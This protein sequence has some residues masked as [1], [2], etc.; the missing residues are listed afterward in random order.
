MHAA[1]TIVFHVSEDWYCRSSMLVFNSLRSGGA[2]VIGIA[3]ILAQFTRKNSGPRIFFVISMI[4]ECAL[5]INLNMIKIR[6]LYFPGE[7]IY[8]DK[9][10]VG[11]SFWLNK[12]WIKVLYSQAV[13]NSSI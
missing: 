5:R 4:C 3:K 1:P 6:V 11:S 10:L 12:G 9:K 8:C 2:G 7:F 13:L